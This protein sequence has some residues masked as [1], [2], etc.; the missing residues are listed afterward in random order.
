MFF[1]PLNPCGQ[2]EEEPVHD[3]MTVPRKFHYCSKWRHDQDAVYW[4]KLKKAQDLGLQFW[5]TK[6]NAF[7]VHHPVPPECIFEVIA[8]MDKNVFYERLSTPRPAPKVTLRSC[9][10]VQQ[11]QQQQQAGHS[12]GKPERDRDCANARKEIPQDDDQV[13]ITT[14]I[15]NKIDLRIDGIP[16][17]AVLQDKMQMKSISETI[18]KLEQI[19]VDLG[20]N[21]NQED[22]VYTKETAENIHDQGNV[23]LVELRQT[24]ETIQCQACWKQIPEGMIKCYLRVCGT[25]HSTDYQRDPGSISKVVQ[26]AMEGCNSI[27]RDEVWPSTLARNV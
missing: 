3:D 27:K 26:T 4:I 14:S 6:S 18:R 23:E 9:W 20:E 11:Q 21:Y 16:Q 22:Y 2:D 5:Q 19:K 17:E 8:R 1:S 12:F 7:I 25:T 15:F 10:Q 24:T 13:E